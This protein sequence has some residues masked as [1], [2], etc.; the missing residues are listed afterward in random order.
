LFLFLELGLKIVFHDI[1]NESDDGLHGL[2]SV[3]M[4]EDL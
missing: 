2:I 4:L 1:V 3:E